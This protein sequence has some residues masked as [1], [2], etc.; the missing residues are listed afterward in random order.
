MCECKVAWW[1]CY[2]YVQILHYQF[3]KRTNQ[4]THH[5]F[6][7]Q[8]IDLW[9][10][11]NHNELFRNSKL[12]RTCV[13]F[14]LLE[15]FEHVGSRESWPTCQCTLD[16]SC[17]SCCCFFLPLNCFIVLVVCQLFTPT[18]MKQGC[19]HISDDRWLYSATSWCRVLGGGGWGAEL[20]EELRGKGLG[21]DLPRMK[22]MQMWLIILVQYGESGDK[23]TWFDK[24]FEIIS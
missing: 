20:G 9:S 22:S 4:L 23:F 3:T 5:I 19:I 7:K 24:L 16:Y 1:H 17:H 13:I 18:I 15:T 8:I 2:K 6:Y 21:D 12:L 14:Y 10:I 11:C